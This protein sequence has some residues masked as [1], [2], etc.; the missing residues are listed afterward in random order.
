MACGTCGHEVEERIAE[1]LADPAHCQS[2]IRERLCDRR[3]HVPLASSMEQHPYCR[4]GGVVSFPTEAIYPCGAPARMRV[5]CQ[6]L[7]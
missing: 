4:M 2:A 7:R 1:T 6:L 3:R 5:R